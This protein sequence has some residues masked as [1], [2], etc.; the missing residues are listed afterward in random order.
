MQHKFCYHRIDI[1]FALPFSE[2]KCVQ[3]NI[4]H[5]NLKESRYLVVTEDTTSFLLT[6]SLKQRT[7]HF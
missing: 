7:F 4:L 3:K 6:N 2:V 5:L 1:A